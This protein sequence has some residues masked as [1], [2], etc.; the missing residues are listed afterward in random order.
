MQTAGPPP[1][2]NDSITPWLRIKAGFCSSLS[3]WRVAVF[4]SW[5]SWLGLQQG[6]WGYKRCI[7]LIM[8]P[9]PGKTNGHFKMSEDWDKNWTNCLQSH[10]RGIHC[11]HSCCH[12]GVCCLASCPKHAC[13]LPLAQSTGYS[14]LFHHSLLSWVLQTHCWH[15]HLLCAGRSYYFSCLHISSFLVLFILVKTCC[16]S[17]G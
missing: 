15:S 5:G 16:C 7:V 14:C 11:W 1:L 17:D 9:Q 12:T 10:H 8:N 3:G 13:A 6:L 2:Y 4:S